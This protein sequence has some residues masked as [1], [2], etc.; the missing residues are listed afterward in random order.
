MGLSY[1]HAVNMG[2]AAAV[3]CGLSA[4]FLFDRSRKSALWWMLSFAAVLL[5]ALSS[6]ALPFVTAQPIAGYVSF[7]FTI[8]A[9]TCLN[10]G[11]AWH[12]RVATPWRIIDTVVAVTLVVTF[13]S[14]MVLPIGPVS[15]T[16]EAVS[17][18]GAQAVGLFILMRS[19]KGKRDRVFIAFLALSMLNFL[20]HPVLEMM[21][22]I[23]NVQNGLADAAVAMHIN[24]ALIM[25]GLATFLMLRLA[26]QLLA[27]LKG[28]SETDALSGLLNR[29]GF[30]AAVHSAR[31]RRS[32]KGTASLVICDLDHFKSINDQH[33]HHVGDRVIAAFGRL[34]RAGARD[35]DVCGRVG[36]EEF[37]IYLLNSDARAA[38]LFAEWLRVAFASTSYSELSSNT[39]FTASFGVTQVQ[40]DETIEEAY[41]RADKAL[42]QAKRDGRNCVRSVGEASELSGIKFSSAAG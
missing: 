1:I 13:I 4:I 23:E 26:N 22:R 27:D 5:S 37:C 10:V 41:V 14:T 28:Q 6:A 34:V 11:I 31:D 16:V 25:I 12:Y 7:A 24:N 21:A 2:L 3:I 20:S 33:G 40:A 32:S 42:Y 9:I 36:G 35:G 8:M 15:W 39:R 19:E 17:L 18:A 38:R 29:N 30:N